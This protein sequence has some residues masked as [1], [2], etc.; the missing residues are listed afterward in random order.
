MQN[1]FQT[2]SAEYSA[3]RLGWQSYFPEYLKQQMV[4]FQPTPWIVGQQLS[5]VDMYDLSVITQATKSHVLIQV[6]VCIFVWKY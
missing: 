4:I 5:K 3:F 6:T 2:N 1:K